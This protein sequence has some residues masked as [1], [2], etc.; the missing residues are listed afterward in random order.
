MN[1]HRATLAALA[2]AVLA[3]ALNSARAGEKTAVPKQVF[4]VN[5]G[6]ASVS[7]VDLASMKEVRRYPV[8][9]RPYG[10]AVSQ[11]GKTVAVGVEDERAVGRPRARDEGDDPEPVPEPVMS[12]PD[13]PLSPNSSPTVRLMPRNACTGP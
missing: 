6:N 8:G 12:E 9:E 11:D 3:P 7:L 13:V 10:I 2:L 1:V 5:T 4:V